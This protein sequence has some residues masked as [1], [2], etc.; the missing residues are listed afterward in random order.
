M[1]PLFTYPLA[2]V[3]LVA[4]PALVAIYLFRNRFRRYP[5]SSLMLWLDAREAREG[6]T[7]LRNLHT[8]LLFLLE[9][10]AIL[11]LIGSAADPHLRVTASARP[12]VVVLDDSY[13]M[14]AGGDDSPR[15]HALAALRKHLDAQPPF[16]TQFVLAG[17]RPQVL[18]KAARTT[19]EAIGQ[20]DGWRCNAPVG[21]LE[22]ALA[23]AGELGGDLALLLVLTDHAPA[24]DAVAD[25]GRLQWWAFGKERDNV[26]IVGAGRTSRDGPDRCLIE[27]ANLSDRPATR[28]LTVEPIDGGAVLDRSRLLLEPGQVR[29]ITLQFPAETPAVRAKMDADDLPIDDEIVLL[30]TAP[31]PVRVTLQIANNRLRELLRRGLDA[32]RVARVVADQPD[33]LFTDRAGEPTAPDRSWVVQFLTGEKDRPTAYSGPFVLDRTSPLTDGLS[34]RGVVWGA[35]KEQEIDSNPVILAGN[36]ALVTDQERTSTAGAVRHHLRLRFRPDV[37]TLQGTPDWPIL[38]TNLVAW[39]SSALPGPERNNVRLG[40]QV[41]INLPQYRESV[42]LTPPGRPSQTLPVKGRVVV[43][44]VDE[45][46]TWK[47]TS[48]ETTWPIA[49]NALDPDESDLR[50]ASKGRWGSWLDETTMRLEYRGLAWLLLLLLLAVAVVHL[51][52]MGQ[53]GKVGP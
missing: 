16:S 30:P 40:E 6:G 31:R 19:G 51:V 5:V 8:P 4:V 50:N 48:E 32:T 35:G 20:L 2:F 21:R 49:V 26:A 41:T 24:K 28:T 29:R 33:L 11:F 53:K 39:R 43:F 9:L 14:L 47:L 37:S 36:T 12:L 18:G 7:R 10:L 23:L 3:G 1:L 27:V 38:V 13:S 52:L 46:G 25:K 22:P 34:L 44:P 42:T 45:T 17:E 15:R